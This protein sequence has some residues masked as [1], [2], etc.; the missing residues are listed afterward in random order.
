MRSGRMLTVF[1]SLLFWGGSGPGGSGP[2]GS[3]PRG[4][5]VLGV[6]VCVS[7][8]GGCV[9]LVPGLPACSGGV[10]PW[11]GGVPGQVPPPDHGG[12]PLLTESQTGVKTLPWPKVCFGR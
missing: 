10:P 1:R 7:G 12:T 4:G 6:C 9:C 11:S 3:G 8:P 5:L 2:G